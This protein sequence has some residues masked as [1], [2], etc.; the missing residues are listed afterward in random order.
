[1]GSVSVLAVSQNP[2]TSEQMRRCLALKFCWPVIVSDQSQALEMLLRDPGIGL[3]VLN[4]PF[5]FCRPLLQYFREARLQQVLPPFIVVAAESSEAFAVAAL[6]AGAADYVAEPLGLTIFS[7]AI[8]RWVVALPDAGTSEHLE[9]GEML[10]GNSPEM[11][12]MRMHIRRVAETDCNV[13]I[14]GE[15]GTGKELVAQLIHQNSSR[16]RHPLVC[17]NCAAIPDSLL[18]S[19]LFGFERG[20]FTGAHSVNQGK[21]MMADKGTVFF[22]EIGDMSPFAQAKILRAIEAK[23][24]QRLGATRKYHTDI[25][26]LAATHNN[27]DELAGTESFRRD[28]YFRL[29]VGRIHLPPLRERKADLPA[30]MNRMVYDLNRRMNRRVE[31]PTREALEKLTQYAWPG[32]VRELKNV[33]EKIFI[34]CGNGKITEQDLPDFIRGSISRRTPQ[35]NEEWRRLQAALISCKG[36]KKKTAESL[37]W[38]RMTLYRKLAKYGLAAPGNRDA[39]T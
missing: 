38:S 21:L 6:R 33:V 35:P 25:R 8:S 24:V 10:V 29:N 27:L 22:D 11:R 31:P 9:G 7:Q 37:C 13:L 19:E 20:A 14:T 17:I 30:L 5:A 2:A 15:T 1:M 26:I 34:T 39:S 23:E 12:A 18:E 28:L 32:N 4:G 16:N 3:V 36:N